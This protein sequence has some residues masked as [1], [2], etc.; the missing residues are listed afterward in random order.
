MAE[1]DD[2]RFFHLLSHRGFHDCVSKL[3]TF[4]A[5]FFERNCESLRRTDSEVGKQ[6]TNKPEAADRDSVKTEK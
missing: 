4:L 1:D 6:L 5:S 3:F 2:F